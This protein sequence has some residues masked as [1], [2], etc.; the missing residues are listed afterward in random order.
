MS[1]ISDRMPSMDSIKD[2][3]RHQQKIFNCLEH[4]TRIINEAQQQNERAVVEQRSQVQNN[5][6]VDYEDDATAI[7][8]DETKNQSFVSEAKK[9]RGVS[10][11]VC[12]Y[13]FGKSNDKFRE[14]H[15]Q[16]DAT[17]AIELR[18]RS[19]DAVQTVLE[20]FVMLVDSIM[21]NSH[22][23]ILLIVHFKDLRIHL[24]DLSHC[25]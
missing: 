14:L 25:T 18:P 9:R 11:F 16:V 3:R 1:V 22:G 6:P 21:R 17:A 20:L 4:L 5:Q 10:H 2:I 7:Y 23:K 8:I 15:H 13:L 12:S 19:G 24:Y